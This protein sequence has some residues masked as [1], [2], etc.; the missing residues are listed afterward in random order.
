MQG[1]RQEQELEADLFGTRIA[2]LAGFDPKGL[3]KLLERLQALRPDGK[4]PLAEVYAYFRS[5]P[6]TGTRIAQLRRELKG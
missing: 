1:Y 2:R 5:H 6:P 4:G 3:V